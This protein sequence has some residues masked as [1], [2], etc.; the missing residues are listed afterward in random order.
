MINAKQLINQMCLKRFKLNLRTAALF[1]SILFLQTTLISAATLSG[2]YYIDAVQGNDAN[3]GNTEQTALKTFTKINNNTLSA[4]TKILLKRDAEW[5]QRLEIRGAGTAANWIT[6][7]DY[8]TGENRPKIS[9]TNDKDDIAL[10]I[11]DL[12]KTSGSPRQQNI[13]YIEVKNLE[14]ANTR[15][16]I[17]YRSVTGTVNTGFR[18]QN[19]IFNNINCDEVMIACNTGNSIAE[20][21][22]QIIA[23]M[24]AVKGNLQT[25]GGNNNGGVNEYIFPAAIFVGGQ[26]FSNQ[27]VSGNHTTVLTEFEVS[28]C[29]FNETMASIMS[30]FYWPFISGG[31]SNIWR[32]IIHKVKVNNCTA[33]GVVNGGIAFD[34]VNGGAI[35]QADG[36]MKP[37]ENGW[38]LIQN[39]AVLRGSA[40]PGRTW[41]NGTTGVILSNS[42]KML[43]NECEF[44]NL[45]NQGNPDG[46]GFDFET[47]TYQVTIQNSKFLNNDGHGMLMMDGGAF[48]GCSEIVIQNNLF[49]G[50][51]K[52]SDS[53]YDFYFSRVQDGHTDVTIKNNISFLNKTNKLNKPI[54]LY[55]PTRTYIKAIDNEVYYLDASA[56][57]IT[58]T[59]AGEQYTY[60]A[61]PFSVKIPVIESLNEKNNKQYTLDTDIKIV[62]STSRA[63]PT[64]YKISEA[65]DFNDADW[66]LY[67]KVVDYSLSPAN[68]L[69]TIYFKVKNVIGESGIAQLNIVL[70]LP[71]EKLDAS[72]RTHVLVS[73]NPVSSRAKITIVKA[74][75][76]ENDRVR[77]NESLYDV[78]VYTLNG[79]LLS[80]SIQKGNEFYLNF[81]GFP[82]GTLLVK[83]ENSNET[84]TK[85]VLKK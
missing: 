52:S 55:D 38:G 37:D 67:T 71:P 42:Q 85:L 66:N 48:G 72:M 16:G 29:E 20:K 8:G 26:T 13:S 65:N 53:E 47:N 19:M 40:V 15:L 69:K 59:F 70:R 5:N 44:S 6:I 58:V 41:P 14:I 17:Y 3:N 50:N 78:Y 39:L 73:P 27:T 51:I 45:I 62:S 75:T 12:D 2:T 1:I 23:H 36:T 10:L 79:L 4:G 22:A 9:L 30:V 28:D 21:N 57:P 63:S 61:T 76:L 32:Q 7:S 84:L 56:Q 18:V 49:A 46:C 74:P 81:S 77:M 25:L 64:Y 24:N 43:F 83:V 54:A 68:G 33:T 31:G 80:Q 34:G 60:N 11:C 35:K 82:T